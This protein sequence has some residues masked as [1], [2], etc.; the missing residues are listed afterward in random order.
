VSQRPRRPKSRSKQ[1]TKRR[2]GRPQRPRDDE[3]DLLR[4]IA[5]ALEA[6]H[7]IYLLAQVSAL[8]AAIDPRDRSPLERTPQPD[9]PTLESLLPTFFDIATPETS[10]LLAAIA[11]LSADQMLRRRVQ[12]EITGRAHAL[13]RW[14]LDLPSTTLAP[15]MVEVA[16]LLGDGDNVL[17]EARLPEGY[18]L[19]A[20]VYIDHN[21]GS[22]VKDAFVVPAPIDE[23]VE[24]LL[25]VADDPDTEARDLS[26]ADARVRITEGI[27]H[28]AL[29]YPP[30]ES[31]SW[32]ACR[33][34]VEWITSL[35]PPGGVG[36]QR[37]EWGD[38]A[39]AELTERF[40]ASPHGAG[41]DDPDH[42]RLLESL[43][44][45]GTD[46]GPGDPLRWSPTAVEILLL[47]W[48]PRKIVA[49]ADYLAKA[50]ELLR[51]FIRFSHDER[52]IRPALTTETVGA[53]DEFEPEYQRLIRSP[54][55]QGPMALLAAMGVPIE[56]APWATPDAELPEFPEVML[57]TLARAVGG[58]EALSA[59]DAQPLP[60][61]EFCW[62]PIPAD[63][64]DRVAEVLALVDGCCDKLLDAECRTAGRRLLARAAAA[65]PGIFRRRGRANTAAAAVC[66]MIGKANDLFGHSASAC[67]VKMLLEHFGLAQGNF[68]Q[69]SGPFL[70][71]IGVAPQPPGRMDLGSPDYLTSGRRAAII[72]DRDR[73][74]ALAT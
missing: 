17:V 40:L 45:F 16:H 11:G 35:L 53:V 27:D 50:P 9:T 36:Y 56:N 33:P 43:L 28:G 26:P 12:R 4:E 73:Y 47:D 48:I 29:T 2:P 72:A 1:R 42:R 66:W 31:D 64:H 74:R 65:D 22:V 67:S 70:R 3:P 20:V 41:L 10:A 8:L 57:E 30:Y 14:L 39:L 55:P 23:L 54:R 61:E 24:Q 18:E 38:A 69:R 60:A 13:P 68:A 19:T 5:D 37:P 62:D 58:D 63:V 44:W 34:L 46:Y 71:A 51:A 25:A 15:R 6:E 7:P 21:A 59:L 52:G 49:E 32:P